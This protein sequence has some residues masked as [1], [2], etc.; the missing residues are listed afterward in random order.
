M[1]RCSSMLFYYKMSDNIT[2]VRKTRWHL[3]VACF[4]HPAVQYNNKGIQ[5]HLGGAANSKF[6]AFF[7]TQIS[8]IDKFVILAY[9]Y[10]QEQKPGKK[11]LSKRMSQLAIYVKNKLRN[12]YHMTL[13]HL[14][15]LKSLLTFCLVSLHTSY[16]IWSFIF[17]ESPRSQVKHGSVL[18]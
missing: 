4:V 13:K 6:V 16:Y 8:I 1:N 12:I 17:S 7:C 9:T 14:W 5:K 2:T 15:P 18:T 10:K 11:T 3:Q